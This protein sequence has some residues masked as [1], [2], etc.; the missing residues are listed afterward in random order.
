MGERCPEGKSRHSR[1]LG[2]HPLVVAPKTTISFFSQYYDIA[3][4]VVAWRKEVFSYLL[5]KVIL[6]ILKLMGRCKY[7]IYNVTR[8]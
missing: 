6:S 1:S 3:Y 8:E 7:K 2:R 5:E 4:T